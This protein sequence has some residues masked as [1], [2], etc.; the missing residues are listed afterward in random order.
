[1]KV[2]KFNKLVKENENN[3]QKLINKY[4]N[5]ELFFTQNELDIIIKKS[6][7]RTYE[8]KNKKGINRIIRNM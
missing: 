2:K 5:G 7:E 1:M 3:L 4:I 6:G 8:R